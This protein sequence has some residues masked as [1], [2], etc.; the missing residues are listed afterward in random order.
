MAVAEIKKLDL[1]LHKS[2][3]EDVLGVLQRVGCCEIISRATDAPQDVQSA[4]ERLQEIDGKISEIRFLLR[5]LEPHYVD[6]VSS[7]D[8]SLGEKPIFSMSE[9]SGVAEKT[10]VEDFSAKMHAYEARL[11]AVRSEISQIDGKLFLLDR[12]QDFPYTMDLLSCGTE[13]VCGLSG[14]LPVNNL[15]SWKN[16]IEAKLGKDAEIFVSRFGEKDAEVWVTLLYARERESD[17]FDVSS[18]Y[19]LSRVEIPDDLNLNPSEEASVLE[20]RKNALKAEEASIMQTVREEAASWVPVIRSLSDYFASLRKRFEVLNDGM[21]TEQ[22][23]AL[24]VWIPSSSVD[25][26]KKRLLP[27][28]SNIEMVLND[29]EKEEI[30]PTLLK[31]RNWVTP[32]ENLTKLYG[33]PLYGEIDP[34]PLL[35]PFFFIYFGMCL[36]D[37][38]Y[39][40]VMIAGLTYFMRKYKRMPSTVRQFMQLIL[41]VAVSTLIYGALTGSWFGDLVDAYDFLGFFRPIKNMFFV[42]DPMQQPMVILGISLAFGVA[43]LAFGLFIAFYDCIRKNDYVAAFGDK[44]AWITML[45]GLL[46]LSGAL[47]AALPEIC[48]PIGKWMAIVGALV[49]FWYQGREKSGIVAKFFSGVLGVYG[50]TSYLGDVLSYSRL[51][52][53]GLASAAIGVIINML[54]KLSSEIPYIGWLIG[55]IV[56]FGGHTFG[57]AVNILGA[58]VHSLR[59]QYVE[60]FSKFYAG[61][62]K[63]FSPL[64]YSTQYIDVMEGSGKN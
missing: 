48:Y 40:A 55:I 58:F 32:Y 6:P 4:N 3:R 50:S 12:F 21:F 9:L 25:A 49:V 11:L 8:R 45:T 54:G 38:G 41:G 33:V 44:G 5:F 62:G 26:L 39:A 24:Q 61:G 10:N 53:L 19:S 59:L 29:P 20:N 16:G 23:V 13:R 63:I 52:A 34:T 51:L 15:Q 7:L 22:T 17:A 35:A 31:N 56:V 14:T 37:A 42:I 47:A 60:F 2:V 36:G 57:L 28:K 18:K 27:F 1:Y 64:T 46:L 30:P 43:H